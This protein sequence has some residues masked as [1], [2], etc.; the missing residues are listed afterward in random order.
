ELTMFIVAH[1]MSTLN[2]C[3]RVMIILD[4]RLAGFDTLASLS[5][6]NEYYRHAA[7]LARGTPGGMLA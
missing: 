5:R 3:D 6:H 1:R 7:A 2:I 4:G